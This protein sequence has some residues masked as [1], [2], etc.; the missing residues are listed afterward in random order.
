MEHI[1]F[2]FLNKCLWHM[3]SKVCYR[4][5]CL[6]QFFLYGYCTDSCLSSSYA[7]YA[8][9]GPLSRYYVDMCPLSRYYVDI[10]L[11]STYCVGRFCWFL[12]VSL[13]NTLTRIV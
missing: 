6:S 7:Y 10:C 11:H 13:I 3:H 2:L 12:A 4:K 1:L 5:I 8:D 9:I